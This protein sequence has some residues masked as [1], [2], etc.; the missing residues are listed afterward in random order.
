MCQIFIEKAKCMKQE[1][2]LGFLGTL[3]LALWGFLH[4]KSELIRKA[5]NQKTDKNHRKKS[6]RWLHFWGGNH[7]TIEKI[8][9]KTLEDKY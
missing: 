3:I 4:L 8:I 7:K 6:L 2:M 1:N 9:S 5:E